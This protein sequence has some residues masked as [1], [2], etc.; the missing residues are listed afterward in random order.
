MVDDARYIDNAAKRR[1]IEYNR[2]TCAAGSKDSATNTKNPVAALAFLVYDI[3]LTFPQEVPLS[4]L[5]IK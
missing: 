2:S 1:V 5:S 3:L 4:A